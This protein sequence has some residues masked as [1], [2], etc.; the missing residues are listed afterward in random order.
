MKLKDILK[1]VIDNEKQLEYTNYSN[2]NE[3]E[4]PYQLMDDKRNQKR[5][6]EYF[7]RNGGSLSGRG[8]IRM[9]NQYDANGCRYC[10]DC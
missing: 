2:K 3:N 10:S 8:R 9:D 1:K 5:N 4:N 6:P 7:R